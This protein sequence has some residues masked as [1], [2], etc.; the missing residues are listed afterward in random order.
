MLEAERGPGASLTD[1]G[2]PSDL[3]PDSPG[4]AIDLAPSRYAAVGAE[5]GAS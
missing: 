3:M 5:M 1:S 2:N 4:R